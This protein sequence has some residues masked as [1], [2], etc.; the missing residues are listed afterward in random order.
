ML[1]RFLIMQV[2][3]TNLCV[4]LVAVIYESVHEIDHAKPDEPHNIINVVYHYYADQYRQR[5]LGYSNGNVFPI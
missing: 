2:I 4:W 5:Q 3:A 1:G